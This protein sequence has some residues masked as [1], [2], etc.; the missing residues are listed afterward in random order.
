MQSH[1]CWHVCLQEGVP[2]EFEVVYVGSLSVDVDVMEQEVRGGRLLLL[3]LLLA[4]G[5]VC[6]SVP[7][8]VLLGAASVADVVA[9]QKM[10]AAGNPRRSLLVD[11]LSVANVLGGSVYVT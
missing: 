7:C 10:E 11:S 6:C 2:D 5:H 4:V 8:V 3:L 1:V 9:E